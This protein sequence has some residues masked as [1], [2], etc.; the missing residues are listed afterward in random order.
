[1]RVILVI[2]FGRP[3]GHGRDDPGH[4][5]FRKY[6][7]F[8]QIGLRVLSQLPLLV[9]KGVN[10]RCIGMSAVG[11][12]PTG[13]SRIDLR[14]I[15]IKKPLIADF[16]RIIH[17]LDHLDMST[18]HIIIIGWMVCC[19]ARIPGGNRLN[20]FQL[21]KWFFHTPKAAAGKDR[22][23]ISRRIHVRLFIMHRILLTAAGNTG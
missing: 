10:R 18:G 11:E 21:H 16:F 17:H 12:L 5:G 23:F 14:P 22:L 1:M 13:V 19:S 15:D 6:M 8:I 20:T 4:D 2:L 9:S 3:E 7:P